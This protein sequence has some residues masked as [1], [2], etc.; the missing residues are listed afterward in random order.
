MCSWIMHFSV[1]WELSVVHLDLKYISLL[2]YAYL[3][4]VLDNFFHKSVCSHMSMLIY[5]NW[6]PFS[7]KWEDLLQRLTVLHTFFSQTSRR[8]PNWRQWSP[9]R[10]QYNVVERCYFWVSH[11]DHFPFHFYTISYFLQRRSE[12]KKAFINCFEYNET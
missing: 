10:K 5:L 9:L 2:L 12:V 1:R 7:V 6:D 3:Y 11:S 8:S 4:L